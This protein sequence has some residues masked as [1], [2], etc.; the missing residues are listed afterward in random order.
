M[1]YIKNPTM[2]IVGKAF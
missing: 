1:K 2:G